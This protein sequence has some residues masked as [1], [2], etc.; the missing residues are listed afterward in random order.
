MSN[1][2][3]HNILQLSVQTDET[4]TFILSSS[5]MDFLVSNLKHSIFLFTQVE[6]SW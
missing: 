6:M 2:S 5:E 1:Q 4:D 3:L